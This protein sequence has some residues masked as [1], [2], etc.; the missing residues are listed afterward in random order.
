MEIFD[1]LTFD[2]EVVTDTDITTTDPDWTDIITM[3]TPD[4]ESATYGLTFSLQFTLNSTSQ[5]FMYRFSTDGGATYGPIYE[6]EVKDRSNTE[7][8]EVLD[9]LNHGGGPIEVSVQVTRE[10]NA[11]CV[12]KKALITCERKGN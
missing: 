9:I 6:K 10:G 7:I 4:R 2:Y 1:I 5:S 3:V 8:I 11:D 12:V